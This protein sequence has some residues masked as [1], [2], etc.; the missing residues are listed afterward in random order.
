MSNLDRDWNTLLRGD[1]LA[2][3]LTVVP[4]VSVLQVCQSALHVPDTPT[5]SLVRRPY[6]SVTAARLRITR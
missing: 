3:L 4:A 5:L 2:D 1:V 6:D